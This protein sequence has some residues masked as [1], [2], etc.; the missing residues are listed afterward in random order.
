MKHYFVVWKVNVN[1]LNRTEQ[2]KTLLEIGKQNVGLKFQKFVIDTELRL[3][4]PFKV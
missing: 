3:T 1:N 4:K 2:N